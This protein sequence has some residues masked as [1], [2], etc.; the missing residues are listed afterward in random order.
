MPALDIL[1]TGAVGYLGSR[2]VERL[3]RAQIPWRPLVG[4][5]EA[6]E[7]GSLAADVVLNCAGALRAR[8][9][10]LGATNDRG[11]AHL[12]EGLRRPAHIVHVSSRAVY[13]ALG[14][15]VL[16]QGAGA[17]SPSDAY[18]RSK[19][20]AERHLDDLPHTVTMLRS[21]VIFGHPAR[22]GVFFDRI[23]TMALA[24][25]AVPVAVPDRPEDAVFVDWVAEAVVNAGLTAD[26]VAQIL[27]LAGPA[28]PLSSIIAALDEALRDAGLPGVTAERC[29]MPVS[30]APLLDATPIGPALGLDPHP[31][32]VEIFRRM[33]S[34]RTSITTGS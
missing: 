26:P 15:H 5:L 32:D 25:Q 1:V 6:V 31:S 22:D 21:T 29:A 27:H 12:V 8:V 13:G 28:R 20:A 2:V 34:A 23:V 30:D 10:R 4:R 14:H 16:L 9:D 17:L 3:N 33:I 24:E 11:T 7:P 18:G 19:L